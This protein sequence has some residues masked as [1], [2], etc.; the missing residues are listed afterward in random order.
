MEMH[1]PRPTA[2]VFRV[3]NAKRSAGHLQQALSLKWSPEV[4]DRS[5]CSVPGCPAVARLPGRGVAPSL[6]A[7]DLVKAEGKAVPEMLQS[8]WIRTMP[9]EAGQS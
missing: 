2:S 7:R 6:Q 9:A 1:L 3:S 5:I 4:T 8:V